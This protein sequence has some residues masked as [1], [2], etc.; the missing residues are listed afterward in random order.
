MTVSAMATGGQGDAGPRVRRA[1]LLGSVGGW[2][3]AGLP[4]VVGGEGQGHNRVRLAIGET[5]ILLML[6]FHR[7]KVEG[8]AAE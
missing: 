4:A 2:L 3:A 8:G 6:S 7:R 5:V 1:L